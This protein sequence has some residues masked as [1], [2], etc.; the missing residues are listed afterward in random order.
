[1]GAPV[2]DRGAF[3]YPSPLQIMTLQRLGLLAILA[4]CS[5]APVP[6]NA[7]TDSAE[8]TRQLTA[9]LERSAGDWNRGD[10]DG[11][12]SDYAADSA[13]SFVSAGHVIKGIDRIRANYTPRFAPGAVHDSLRFEELEARP[14]GRDHALVTARYVLF[15]DGKTS[16]S[17]PFTLVLEQRLGGWKILHDQTSTDP[18]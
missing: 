18:R 12:L 2:A 8:L 15:R 7:G 13:T 6:R 14:L 5:P 4:G 16:A 9:Q 1:M 3:A 11:F 17:G 10:L